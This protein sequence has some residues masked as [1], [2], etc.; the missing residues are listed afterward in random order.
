LVSLEWEIYSKIRY[1]YCTYLD[2][3]IKMC[4]LNIFVLDTTYPEWIRIFSNYQ[5]LV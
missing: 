4:I 2:S 5:C 1:R 3:G